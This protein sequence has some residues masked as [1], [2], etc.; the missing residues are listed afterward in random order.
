MDSH[1]ACGESYLK[2]LFLLNY[3]IPAIGQASCAL[4]TLR[5]LHLR[6]GYG[7]RVVKYA[8]IAVISSTVKFSTTG[9]ICA[10]PAPARAPF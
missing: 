4:P 5:L 8:A 3:L 6:V 10:A 7:E 9:F 1:R 2:Y